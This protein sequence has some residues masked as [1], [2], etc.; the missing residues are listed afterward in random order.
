MN[1]HLLDDFYVVAVMT[2]PERFNTRAR[3]FREFMERMNKYG[4]NLFVVEGAFGEREFEVTDPSNPW[5]I[6][7]RTESE[8]W[9][10]EN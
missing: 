10:K 7:I 2:N 9:H 4:V 1:S 6:Q 3:L 5:H 8:L